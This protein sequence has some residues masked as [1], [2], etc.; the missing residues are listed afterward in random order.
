M[1][2]KKV[3]EKR[4]CMKDDTK[5]S[6]QERRSVMKGRRIA[7]GV[8][9]LGLLGVVLVGQSLSQQQQQRAR[10]ARQDFRRDFQARMLER[11]KETLEASDEEWKVIEPRVEKVLTLSRQTRVMAGFGQR[12]RPPQEQATG[13]QATGQQ[14]EQTQ[15]EKAQQDLR[16]V[17]ENKQAKPEE[18]KQKLTALREA[19]EKA[20]QELAKAQQDLREILNVRQEAQLVLMGLLN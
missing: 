5:S 3:Q 6:L 19:V 10:P 20:K 16:T 17:L 2:W 9:I 8:L 11:M 1:K 12:F 14:A 7:L 13:Q 4:N 15:V 18:I